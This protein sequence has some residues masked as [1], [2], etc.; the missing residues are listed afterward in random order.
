[1]GY[2]SEVA[3]CLQVKEPEKFI[4]LAR[5]DADDALKEM[6]DNM[7]YVDGAGDIKYILF[8]HNYWKWYE[9]SES[10]FNKLMELSENYDA[11]YACKF[12]R[13]G[14][15]MDDVEEEKFGED[16]WDLEYPY[17]VR[18]LELGVKAENLTP[19]TKKEEKHA[20]TS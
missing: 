3:F 19:I 8:T 9:D 20:T 2:R 5:I 14:E 17:V 1:M 10:A 16:G 13:V 18:Q 11:E 6:I 12:A 7:Y 4:A 15:E